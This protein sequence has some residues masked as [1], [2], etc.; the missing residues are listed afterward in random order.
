MMAIS[1]TPTDPSTRL[2]TQSAAPGFRR[3]EPFHT[4]HLYGNS[5]HGGLWTTLSVVPV[6]T[7]RWQYQLRG[8]NQ[9][10][11][12][13]IIGCEGTMFTNRTGSEQPHRGPFAGPDHTW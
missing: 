13:K 4:G 6:V 7:A 12:H 11:G 10:T 9:R 2:A 8:G 3:P 5:Q 1:Q